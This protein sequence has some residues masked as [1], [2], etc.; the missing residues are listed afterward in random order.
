MRTRPFLV[1]GVERAGSS[2]TA[3]VSPFDGSTVAEVSLPSPSDV[4]DALAAA[5]RGFEAVRRLPA[6]ERSRML[7]D[8]SSSLAARRE[9]FARTIALEAGKPIVLARAEVDRA[10]LTLR[11]SAEEA[12]RIL[13]ETIPLD[14]A[15]GLERRF[16][17]TRRF[18]VGPVLCIT[19][20]NFPL[21]LAAHKVGPALAAGCAA[22][23]KPASRTPLSALDLGALL[24]EAGFPREAVSVLP[25]RGADAGAIA[26]DERIR[27]VSFTGSA[28]VGWTLKASV[29][30]K[31]VVLELG[32]NAGLIVDRSA[33]LDLAAERTAAGGFAFAGQSCISVQRVFV[34]EE[35]EAAFVARLLART[36]ELPV[37][38]PLDERVRVGPMITEEDAIRAEGWVREAVASGARVLAGGA[39]RG[40][41]LDPTIL[42]GTRP[43]MKVCDRETFA[44]V[45]SVEAFRDFADAVAA[46]DRSEFGLQAGV[47]TRDL[48]SVLAAFEGIEVGTL[49]VNDAPTFRADPMPYG[50]VKSSGVGREGPRYAIEDFTELRLLVVAP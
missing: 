18:P 21:N 3:V 13:G 15:P 50:G 38:D 46:V 6:W 17:I 16:G 26:A 39:R 20:F 5:V 33:D 40:S 19:P 35:V 32:G 2:V 23:L 31:K 8:A 34:H 9:T 7:R 10:V 42:T 29:P 36:A 22:V 41:V 43:G 49:V 1:G 11:A 45:V 24:L 12:E 4:E 14:V 27:A 47:F 44:P 37:G 48:P 28:E 30:R 25:V